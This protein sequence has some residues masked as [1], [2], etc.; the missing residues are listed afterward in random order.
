[1]PKLG[2]KWKFSLSSR[3]KIKTLLGLIYSVFSCKCF[4]MRRG[5]PFHIVSLETY[6]NMLRDSQLINKLYERSTTLEWFYRKNCVKMTNMLVFLKVFLVIIK[7]LPWC[8]HLLGFHKQK[9]Q[10]CC[11]SSLWPFSINNLFLKPLWKVRFLITIFKCFGK[12]VP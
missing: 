12:V 2:E 8:N 4:D 1:M 11:Y 3:M 6:L 5:F 10:C 7:T 9:H